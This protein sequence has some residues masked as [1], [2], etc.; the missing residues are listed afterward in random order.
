MKKKIFIML[1]R[2]GDIINLLPVLKYEHEQ[3]NYKPG[4]L[5]SK[6]YADMLEG[7]SYLQPIIFDGRFEKINEAIASIND[8]YADYEIINCAVYGHSYHYKRQCHSFLREAWHKSR[9][10]IAFGQLPLVFDK[11]NE[12]RESKLLYELNL[13]ENKKIIVTALSGNSSIFHQANYLLAQLK[14]RLNHRDYQIVDISNYRATRFYDLLALYEIADCLVASDSAPLHLANAVPSLDVISLVNDKGT[15][16]QS[17]WKPN[18]IL[19]MSYKEVQHRLDDIV[20]VIKTKNHRKIHYLTS[21]PETPNEETKRRINFATDTIKREMIFTQKYWTFNVYENKLPKI[22]DMINCIAERNINDD[23]IIFIAN[24]DI[25]IVPNL[26]GF[27]LNLRKGGAAYFHR[28]DFKRLDKPLISEVEIKQGSW[29]IGSDAFAF[30]KRWWLNNRNIFPD[31]YYAREAWDM[32]MRNMIKRF[33][34]FEIFT[35]IYHEKHKSFWE[36]KEGKNCKEN[37]HNRRVAK[38]WL[39]RYGGDWLDPIK[40]NVR[41]K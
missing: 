37:V 31:M 3:F 20:N 28:H 10:P 1:G 17:D 39:D 4:L 12:E 11:R 6:D 38:Q 13:K 25:S 23:D 40:K 21:M 36:S 41:Y 32:I 26:T 19:R 18:H 34:G 24:S 29:Y 8:R 33:H 22:K 35:S 5:V 15:W 30:T 9:C 27:L 7:C 16:Y 2:Y 14:Q